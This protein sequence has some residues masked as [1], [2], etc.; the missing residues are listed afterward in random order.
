MVMDSRSGTGK[1]TYESIRKKIIF[2]QSTTIRIRENVLK[3]FFLIVSSLSI[4]E[5][6]Y[7][8]VE[9]PPHSSQG[10]KQQHTLSL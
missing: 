3:Y 6:A 8:V 10:N 9:S 5:T 4:T 7:I 2:I 1:T